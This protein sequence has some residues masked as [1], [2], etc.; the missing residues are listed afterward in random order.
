[1]RRILIFMVLII[2][3]LLPLTAAARGTVPD[4]AD[5]MAT[6][7]D[8][9][10]MRRVGTYPGGRA[11]VTIA[12]TVPVFL[13]DLDQSSPLARQMAEEVTRWFVT[14]GYRVDELRK[15]RD[16]TMEPRTGEM[17][18]TRQL[19]RLES[20]QVHTVAILAGTYTITRD[21][22]RFNLRLLHTPSN[23]VLA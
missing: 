17:I 12:T 8:Q 18:L 11:N 23:Q 15:G 16:I 22:V 10:I 4:A 6:Q 19:S 21:N 14:A 13:G 3:C 20:T 2:A 1:M 7:M 9:Q 5:Q